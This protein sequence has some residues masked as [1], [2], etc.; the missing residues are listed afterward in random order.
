MSPRSSHAP[1]RTVQARSRSQ[2]ELLRPC[3]WGDGPDERTLWLALGFIEAAHHL[4]EQMVEDEFSRQYRSSRVLLHLT[5]HAVE[6]FVKG[7]IMAATHERP[8]LTHRLRELI[9]QYERIYPAAEFHF[10]VPFE[11][12]DDEKQQELFQDIALPP[13]AVAE[14]FR[15]ATS[16]DGSCFNDIEP[17]DPESYLEQITELYNKFNR[18]FFRLREIHGRSY[19]AR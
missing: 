5:H 15:Y 2:S 14:S 9:A 11:L 3:Y 10:S 12:N 4:C 19:E 16:V 6:L 7:A 18:L 17:F 13:I 8:R 1:R